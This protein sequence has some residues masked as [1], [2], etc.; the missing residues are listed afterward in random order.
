MATKVILK[1]ENTGLTQNAFFGFSWTT[2]FFG[3]FPAL[4]RRD[5]VTFVGAL[6]ILLI[7]GLVTSGSGVPIANLVWAFMYNKYHRWMLFEKGYFLDPDLNRRSPLIPY[8]G[9]RETGHIEFFDR[10][11]PQIDTYLLHSSAQCDGRIYDIKRWVARNTTEP[12]LEVMYLWGLTA[13]KP[14][15]AIDLKDLLD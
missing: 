4:F 9:I 3:M 14:L 7:F 8:F 5:F 12:V 11:W 13:Y 10:L 6:A 1:Q 15:A 2:L